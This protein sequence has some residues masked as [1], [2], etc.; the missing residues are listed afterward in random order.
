MRTRV[1]VV[2][3]TCSDLCT[4]ACCCPTRMGAGFDPVDFFVAEIWGFQ[5]ARISRWTQ[6]PDFERYGLLQIIWSIPKSRE[7][8]TPNLRESIG[9]S[10]NAPNGSQSLGFISDIHAIFSAKFG[11]LLVSRHFWR[12]KPAANQRGDFSISRS[13]FVCQVRLQTIL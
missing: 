7:L 1:N 5:M 12:V 8:F 11:T 4:Y 3:W 13:S 10:G 6:V 2:S 9:Q